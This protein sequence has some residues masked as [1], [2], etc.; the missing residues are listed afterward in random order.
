L[1]FTNKL[2]QRSNLGDPLFV[3]GMAE[4]QTE[5]LSQST[6]D[7][8]RSKISDVRTQNVS[9]YDPTGLESLDT[10]VALH[11]WSQAIY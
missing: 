7:E 10:Y 3:D 4:Y 6:I 2:T 11:S 9:A 8:I 5:M 1:A